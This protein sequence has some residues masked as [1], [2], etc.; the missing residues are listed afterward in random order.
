M[1]ESNPPRELS[2]GLP[3]RLQLD[4][5]A[6]F[7]ISGAG[8]ASDQAAGH[9]VLLARVN[10]EEQQQ[11]LPWWG[12]SHTHL[13]PRMEILSVQP[14]AVAV[15]LAI[16]G[17]TLTQRLAA[18][19]HKHPVD[20][21]RTALRIAD[22]LAL[23][24]DAKGVHGRVHPDNVLLEPAQGVEP[25]LV[26]GTRAPP[27]FRR[28]ECSQGEAPSAP[29]DQW[30]CVAL[31][32]TM[33]TGK[34]P[35]GLGLDSLETL[36]QAGVDDPVLGQ[37]L[38]HGLNQI[39]GERSDSLHSF[40]RELAR[41]YIDHAGEEPLHSPS[42]LPHKPP[43]L[44]VSQ[45]PGELAQS[46]DSRGPQGPASTRRD[47]AK[48]RSLSGLLRRPLPLAGVAAVLGLLGAWAVSSLRKPAPVVRTVAS[49]QPSAPTQGSAGP[50]DLAE[51]P[52][53]GK[54]QQVGD[55]TANCATSY[56]R[57]GVLAPTQTM[58]W[59]CTE[60]DANQLLSRL[61]PLLRSKVPIES[62]GLY[63]LAIAEALRT[64]CCSD[65]TPLSLPSTAQACP[66]FGPSL[67]E[68]GRAVTT[69]PLTEATRTRFAKAVE[70]M[71]AQRPPV[72]GIRATGPSSQAESE[73]RELFR[74]PQS[75]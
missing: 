53:T 26:F 30:A 8:L 10:P 61:T 47:S 19:G 54:E 24:H 49:A 68:L 34:P 6:A 11:L 28:P 23:I 12:L 46:P 41:W 71:A 36:K 63:S 58:G 43:P 25:I 73:F 74:P 72:P 56:L 42:T 21:V 44:P 37:V 62:L 31:L 52:V 60:R 64:A 55:S 9:R 14:Q 75:Q 59:L 27:A 50:I 67:N 20:A 15:S 70:C 13:A 29:D 40:K 45:R 4:D 5:A 51:V 48:A 38:L 7:D 32:H 69:I 35:P 65:A 16:E 1:A 57:E 22:A 66:D 39:P 17:T 3:E 2:T 33:L 18:I